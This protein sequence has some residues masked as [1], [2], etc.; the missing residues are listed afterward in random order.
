MPILS[1]I[2]RK[3][4]KV[5][6]LIA[7]IYLFLCIGG[8]TMIYPF[9][10]MIAGSTKSGVDVR[11]LNL[12]PAYL[13]DDT[14]LYQKYVEGLFNESIE[15][16]RIAYDAD[17]RAFEHVQLPDSDT[18]PKLVDAW[19]RFLE[20]ERIPSYAVWTGYIQARISR[21]TPHVLR[22]FK[23][24]MLRRFDRDIH[25]MN[26]ELQT[27]FVNWNAFFVLPE[28]FY[29][30]LRTYTSD[31]FQD[32]YRDF[33]QDLSPLYS[34]VASIK[35]FYRRSYLPNRFGRDIA[36]FNGLHGTAYESYDDLS[37]SP[38][39]PTESTHQ[40]VLWEPFVRNTLNLLW[41]RVD[42][43]ATEHYQ[44]FLEAK[45]QSIDALNH[46]YQSGHRDFGE[47]PL[48][49]Q[50]PPE[51]IS[52]S[53][54]DQ[55]IRGWEDPETGDLFAAPVEYLK[56]DAPEFR[57][58]A[59]LAEQYGDIDAI[60]EQWGTAFPSFSSIAMPQAA[61]HQQLFLD[62]RSAL[63]R[64]F[65]ARNYLTVLDY[66]VFH[67]RGIV[68]TAIYCTL[69][70]L[71]ALLVNPMAAYAMSRYRMPATYKI[72]LFL[73]LTM[74]FP[75]IVTQIPAFLMLRDLNLLNTFAALVLPGMAHGYSIFLLKG[76]FDS[77]PRDLYES[78]EIDGAN[79]WT[80][81]WQISMSLSKP[82]LAVIALNAFIQAYSNFMFALLICQDEQMW[83]LM[84]WLYQL[85]MRSGQG[86]VYASLIIAAIPTFIIFF[87]CQ[88][89]ILR[90]IVVPVEK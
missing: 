34:H 53:D 78:A 89:I 26:R 30:R 8:I 22:Q 64:E 41:V 21:T 83:T 70:V 71:L 7:A 90:G 82:I 14:A 23:H 12:I 20:A 10:L 81:F 49:S 72:L 56:I 61:F 24:A 54:W 25:R 80:M 40:Q 65:S 51:G 58:H 85:Q 28:N 59:F 6:F 69:A 11:D 1:P 79:E 29:T 4:P 16:Y 55:F 5:R 31:P 46:A 48:P 32:A 13:R 86:V 44:Q 67:G 87:F 74:A 42:P 88:Q 68:N 33:A 73:L 75:P 27:D 39:F 35:G 57:F 17:D 37:L 9:A 18:P 60:N 47:I 36:S 52:T 50:P 15:L 43:D 76:F 62:H 19:S 63:R 3:H 45:Y 2:G 77:L 38:G 66:M 84:V